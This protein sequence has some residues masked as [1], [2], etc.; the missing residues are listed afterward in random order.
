MA[1][2]QEFEVHFS[3]VERS[4]RFSGVFLGNVV[5]CVKGAFKDFKIIHQPLVHIC[6]ISQDRF[7]IGQWQLQKIFTLNVKYT[8]LA[9]VCRKYGML[10]H[11]A[12]QAVSQVHYLSN[13]K[14]QVGYTIRIATLYKQFLSKPITWSLS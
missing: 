7:T 13:A 2:T 14:F 9:S 1:L 8:A 6:L 3:G 4:T 10:L 12:V 5:G 11:S